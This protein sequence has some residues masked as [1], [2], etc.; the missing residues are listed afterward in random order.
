LSTILL[1]FKTNL[2]FTRLRQIDGCDHS[3]G[4]SLALSTHSNAKNA[5]NSASF[6]DIN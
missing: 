4:F 3:Y 2:I 1:E 6:A 5:L